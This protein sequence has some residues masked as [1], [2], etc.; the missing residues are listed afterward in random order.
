[1]Y[2][3]KET[4]TDPFSTRYLTNPIFFQPQKR[5]HTNIKE[6]LKRL[7]NLGKLDQIYQ[8]NQC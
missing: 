3:R 1:M 6:H 8:K 2:F 4:K 7:K 5:P